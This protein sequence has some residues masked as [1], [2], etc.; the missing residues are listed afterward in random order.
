MYHRVYVKVGDKVRK[1]QLLI[2]IN[3]EEIDAKKAQAQA[4]FKQAE[5]QL[6]RCTKEL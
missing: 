1:G 3:S 6:T 4:G 5:A 2:D